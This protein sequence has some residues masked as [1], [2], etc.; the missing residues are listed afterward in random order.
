MMGT[1]QTRGQSQ[2]ARA[3]PGNFIC[4][5]ILVFINKTNYHIIILFSSVLLITSRRSYLARIYFRGESQGTQ[6]L[7]KIVQCRTDI[8]KH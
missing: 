5:N 3:T 2:I 4:G 8:D 1:A 7:V 6:G